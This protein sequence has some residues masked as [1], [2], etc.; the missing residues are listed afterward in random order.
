MKRYT[1]EA[2][3]ELQDD[4]Y[5]VYFPQLPDAYTSGNSRA[6]AIKNAAEVLSLIVG[7]YVDEGKQ[8][9]KPKRVAE[10]ISVSI[11][12][13][14]EDIESMKYLSLSEA[15]EDL[16][17]TPGRITQLIKAGKLHD[18]YFGGKRMVSIESVNSVM[19]S[20]RKA[21]RPSKEKAIAA[22]A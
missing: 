12:L 7:E 2:I 18:K 1:Y 14:D 10:C 6:D 17:V 9:P 11:V 15:A 13:S 16:E 3:I 22:S 20:S 8:L 4:G 21:G 5:Y 19:Q